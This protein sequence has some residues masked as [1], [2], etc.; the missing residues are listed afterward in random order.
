MGGC[1]PRRL[2]NGQGD[3]DDHV[4]QNLLDVPYLPRNLLDSKGAKVKVYY[5]CQATGPWWE[6]STPV[7]ADHWRPA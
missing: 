4:F 3:M 6:D 7:G 5:I 2:G 1:Q